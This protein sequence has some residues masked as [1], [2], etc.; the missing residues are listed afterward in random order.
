LL[1]EEALREEEQHDDHQAET[2]DL[3]G[4]GGDEAFH[5][6]LDDAEA[7]AGDED[8]G[9]RGDAADDGHGERLEADDQAHGGGSLYDG[10]D[11]D[12][13]GGAEQ[14][15]K[16]KGEG[17]DPVDVDAHQGSRLPVEGD[18]R[19]GAPYQRAALQEAKPQHGQ[20][21]HDRDQELLRI[22][23]G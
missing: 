10:G 16:R 14:R 18:G 19:H 2:D 13:G 5:E 3:P 23:A 6:L 11:E 12:A 17:D 7:E 15:G 4:G 1:A 22:D 9:G 8:A 20:D 21:R